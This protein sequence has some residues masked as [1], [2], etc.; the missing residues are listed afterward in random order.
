MKSHEKQHKPNSKIDE[1][2]Y[3]AEF[4]LDAVP[5]VPATPSTVKRARDVL[6]GRKLLAERQKL[7]KI[8]DRTDLGCAVVSKYTAEELADGS[9]DEKCLEKAEKEAERKASRR[10]RNVDNR[11]RPYRRPTNPQHV[12][13]A[14]LPGQSTMMTIPAATALQYKRQMAVP[15]MPPSKERLGSVSPAVRWDT[16]KA[17]AQGMQSSS[18]PKSW[19]PQ[20]YCENALHCVDEVM[21][22]ML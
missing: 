20:E 16:S 11:Q 13:E 18:N 4:E 3:E 2:L 22:L 12:P 6:R 14:N 5:S 17:T 9:E 8:A 21:I 1:A 19:Y 10:K 15:R 7:I